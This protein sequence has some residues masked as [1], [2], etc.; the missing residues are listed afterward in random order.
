MDSPL[1][2][3]RQS[4][5]FYLEQ[6]ERSEGQ[7]SND[8]RSAKGSSAWCKAWQQRHG[9]YDTANFRVFHPRNVNLDLRLLHV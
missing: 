3:R 8:E 9:N 2:I 6:R 1:M 5:A 4:S 7:F